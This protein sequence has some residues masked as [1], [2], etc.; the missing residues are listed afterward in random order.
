VVR[1]VQSGNEGMAYVE[2]ACIEIREWIWEAI[3]DMTWD[4]H[5]PIDV[6]A[7]YELH[8]ATRQLGG[9]IREV[10]RLGCRRLRD[11]Y[12]FINDRLGEM[13]AGYEQRLSC[14]DHVDDDWWCEVYLKM[15]AQDL[16]SLDALMFRCIPRVLPELYLVKY[17]LTNQPTGDGGVMH[18]LD[19]GEAAAGEYGALVV[20]LVLDHDYEHTGHY[21]FVPPDSLV[22]LYGEQFCRTGFRHVRV[23]NG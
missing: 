15:M 7:T 3:V 4:I 18:V 13:R 6:S 5:L 19:S 16:V 17:T 23:E 2:Y 21:N 8:S 1:V 22:E 14:P 11:A 12:Q 20:F 10:P 9:A